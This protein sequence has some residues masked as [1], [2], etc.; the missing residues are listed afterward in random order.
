MRS[1]LFLLALFLSASAAFGQQTAPGRGVP[2]A[3]GTSNCGGAPGGSST[4]GCG[5]VPG[6]V[7][8]A[9]VAPS[10]VYRWTPTAGCST[11]TPCAT[12][13]V[14]GNNATQTS[15]GALPTY[16]ATGG[17]NSTPSLSFN[18]SDSAAFGT[19][20]PSSV[21][22]FTIYAI[23]NYST[24]TSNAIIGGTSSG[25]I[26]YRINSSNH[27]DLLIQ[28]AVDLGTG[29]QTLS[30]NTWY[31]E[32]ITYQISG[33]YTFYFASGGNLTAAGTGSGSSSP[34]SSGTQTLGAAPGASEMF[35]G[36]IA[37]WGYL[38]SVNTSGIATWSNCHFNI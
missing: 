17:P 14:A 31:T 21:T 22:A 19:A 26:E 2:T 25:A 35:N 36:Q 3:S 6:T 38:D 18:G 27:P 12:D 20:I 16:S 8:P 7:T 32:V 33:A 5:G 13:Q 37:E 9:C 24:S 29:T 15:S 10:M 28:G 34:F 1:K 4:T 30:P 11:S 23:V